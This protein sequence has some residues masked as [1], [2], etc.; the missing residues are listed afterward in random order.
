MSDMMHPDMQS[1]IMSSL[2]KIAASGKAPGI[3]SLDDG[4]TQKSLE[5]GAKFVAVGIDIV[6]LTNHSRALSTKWKSNL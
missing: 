3:L 2:K 6:T 1:V 4:M 5:A